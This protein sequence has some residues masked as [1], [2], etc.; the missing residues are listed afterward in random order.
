MSQRRLASLCLVASTVVWTG[1][2][3][4]AGDELLVD[5]HPTGVPMRM[6]D[7]AFPGFLM[8]GFAPSPAA[9]LGRGRWAFEVHFSKVNDFQTSGAVEEYL[10]AT[11]GVGVRRALDAADASYV[12]GLPQGKGFYV[13]LETDAVEIAVHRGITDRL[14]LGLSLNYFHYGGGF[15]DGVVESFHDTFSLG[16]GGRTHVV[17]NHAQVV[18]GNDGAVFVR[19]L[20]TPSDGG[21]G[22][23][24]LFARYAL[25]GQLAGW[26]FNLAAGAKPPLASEE[27][28]VSSGSWDFGLQL[29]ADR[30][31]R[32]N[33]L[34]VNLAA[35]AAG[36]FRDTEFRVGTD[37]P[38][39][40]AVHVSWLHLLGGSYRART[41]L[42]LLFAQHP[43]RDLIASDFTSLEFQLTGGVKWDTALGTWGVGVTENLFNFD[44][45]P[46]IGIHLSWGTVVD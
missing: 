7:F 26:R 33:A 36:D 20:E 46:D 45:T 18:I 9:A 28:A 15:L 4:H 41:F 17:R 39:L 35:V 1:A 42:Q 19:A 44:N 5:Q 31:W 6:R 43:L 21:F 30:R 23:P 32:R 24:F 12:L 11:R 38:L 16:Q 37:I 27:R 13:D 22:D 29:T 14:D 40:P 25:P 34:I 3:A 10:A 2:T 8:L